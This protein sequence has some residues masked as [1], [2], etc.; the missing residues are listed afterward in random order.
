M[1]E[2]EAELQVVVKGIAIRELQYS[3]QQRMKSQKG[4]F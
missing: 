4:I 2:T 3:L 1:E